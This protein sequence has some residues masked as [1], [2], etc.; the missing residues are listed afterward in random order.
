LTAPAVLLAE[1]PVVSGVTLAQRLDGS[2]LVDVT[3]TLTDADTD[4]LTVTLQASDDGGQT[5]TLPVESVSGD[6]GD[7]V[8]PGTDRTAVWDFGADHPGRVLEDVRVRVTASDLGVAWGAHSP[9]LP[10]IHAWPAVDWNDEKR[11]EE[12][13]RTDLLVLLGTQLLGQPGTPDDALDRIRRHNPNIR[14]VAYM[15]AK[16]VHL[17]WENSSN[18][19]S[20]Q[21]FQDTRPYWSFT[22][23]GDTLM[24]W[25]DQVV[26][27]LIEPEC[28]QAMVD[29]YV[30]W[31]KT[32]PN[33]LDGVF[34]DYFN[35]T[36]WVP[37]WMPVDGDPDLDGDG[38]IMRSDPD[39]IEAWRNACSAM[40]T[41]V[42]DSMGADFIQIFN[43]QRA[44]TDSTFAALGD[45]MN[46]ELFPDVF[47]GQFGGVSKALDHDYEYNLYR[48]AHWPRS[49]NGGPFVLLENIQKNYYLSSVDGRYH[50]LVNGKI[51][52]VVS[53][54][55][56]TRCVFN[57]H[58]YGWPHHPISLG[59][60]LGP[61]QVTANGLRRDFRHGDVELTW[62][63]G[64]SMP[65]PFDY[66]IRVDGVIVEEMRIP[67]EYPLTP[68]YFNP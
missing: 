16:T 37:A 15:L 32:S 55:T 44:Y 41:A 4:T 62:R 46:Y 5:W 34:W 66:V 35:N 24:D 49:T 1:A 3:Y 63:N 58:K 12:M 29:N 8:T 30:H 45:G 21:I 43:G 14:I 64:G 57:G 51:L 39:E 31:L 20:A 9:R 22:T 42:Q 65:T 17:A 38:V 11:L 59:E 61:A 10:A 54:M 47:F 33:R 19:M 56:D 18:P 68:E 23:E 36:I 26:I 48:T 40:V 6:A 28:R 27:N 13:A 2:G 60:P 50:E 53:L 67:Y 25:T 7:G 52:R